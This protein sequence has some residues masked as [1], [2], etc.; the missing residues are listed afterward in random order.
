MTALSLVLLYLAAWAP[1]GRLGLT[2]VAGLV[3]AAAVVSG[4]FWTGAACYAATSLL[5]A[6]LL[7]VKDSFVLYVLFFGL[8]PLAKYWVERIGRLAVEWVLKLAAFNLILSAFLF[9]LSGIFF[10]A[11]PVETLPVWAAYLAG[12]LIFIVYDFGM[13]KV[14]TF[15]AQRIDRVLRK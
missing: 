8:Y 3:P 6:V 11:L 13:S 15:Y 10:A 1:S 2:A 7:P 9:G 14:M 5:S 4:G 12:N